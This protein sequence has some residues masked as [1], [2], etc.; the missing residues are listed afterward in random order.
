MG[1][2]IK[3]DSSQGAASGEKPLPIGGLLILVAIG[4]I[5]N[6]IQNLGQYSSSLRAVFD[7]SIWDNV[8]DPHSLAYHPY[9]KPVLLYEVMAGPVFIF[10]NVVALWLFFRKKRVFPKL[11]VIL[12]PS[13]FVLMLVDYYLLG[14][15]PT[16][17]ESANYSRHGRELII[18]FF[19]MH[20]WIPY[21]LLS[22]RV[23]KTFLR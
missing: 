22:D 14:L 13:F 2:T 16:I 6:L 1:E 10:L 20:I 19:A 21:F 5:I 8:T 7:S 4:L 3:L 15:I 9:W 23:Q 18:R 17:A 11:M 12:I